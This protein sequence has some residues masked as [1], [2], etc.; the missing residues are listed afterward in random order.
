MCIY[1]FNNNDSFL[2]NNTYHTYN[3]RNQNQFLIANKRLNI[4]KH[5]LLN[6]GPKLFNKLPPEIQNS[7]SITQFKRLLKRFLLEK[8]F[9]HINTFLN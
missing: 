1:V 7:R 6:L 5:F 4:S 9:Y 3:T 8:C 2:R